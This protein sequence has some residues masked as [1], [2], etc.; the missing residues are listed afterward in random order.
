MKGHMVLLEVFPESYLEFLAYMSSEWETRLFTLCFFQWTFSRELHLLYTVRW[1]HSSSCCVI[2]DI[3]N[4]VV[5]CLSK[6]NN[7]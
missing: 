3:V 7:H 2:T 1:V 4:S 5:T 6:A